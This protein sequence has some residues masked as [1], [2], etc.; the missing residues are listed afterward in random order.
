MPPIGRSLWRGKAL[1][2]ICGL[3]PKTPRYGIR[4]VAQGCETA[5]LAEFAGVG[6]AFNPSNLVL[7]PSSC[8]RGPRVNRGRAESAA[9]DDWSASGRDSTPRL[10]PFG[11]FFRGN[12]PAA[13]D[14]AR[15]GRSRQPA[16]P[17][18]KPI[19][20]DRADKFGWCHALRARIGAP[21]GNAGSPFHAFPII[22]QYGGIPRG[23]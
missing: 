15:R 1:T 9:D 22:P 18:V 12:F 4:A 7:S 3:P 11:Q 19:K 16:A 10:P 14:P 6:P 21:I 23:Q 13:R 20:T 5:T 8:A 17:P 2:P